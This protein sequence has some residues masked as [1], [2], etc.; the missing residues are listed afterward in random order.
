MRENNLRVWGRGG[1]LGQG[2]RRATYHRGHPRGKDD[3]D[4]NKA[5]RPTTTV[6]ARGDY[7]CHPH[8]RSVAHFETFRQIGVRHYLGFRAGNRKRQVSGCVKCPQ[9]ESRGGAALSPS[10]QRPDSTQGFSGYYPSLARL[11]FRVSDF[12]LE[13]VERRCPEKYRSRG[14]SITPLACA[15]PPTLVEESDPCSYLLSVRL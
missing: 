13:R 6:R 9:T 1:V 8:G 5:I 10:S 11:S 15:R 2:G 3:T 7:E 14:R 4:P 12:G